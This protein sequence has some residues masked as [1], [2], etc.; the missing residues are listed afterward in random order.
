[1]SAPVETARLT[2]RAFRD[3]DVEPLFAIQGDPDAMRYTHAAASREAC[4]RWHRTF[5]ALETTLGF[6]PW[7]VVL[8]EEGRVIGW[9]GLSVDPFEPGWGIEVSYYFHPAYWGR[10][11]ATELVRATLRH[12]FDV[13]ALEAIGA[14]VRPANAASARVLEK[15]GLTLCGYEPRLERN[16]YAIQRSAWSAR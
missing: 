13:L 5:A 15:C 3:E 10:G 16:R 1:M 2:L 9:G 12:G 4:A 8:R 14:F 6:A 11:F 7:T